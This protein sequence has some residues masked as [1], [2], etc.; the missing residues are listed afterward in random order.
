MPRISTKENRPTDHLTN[1]LT[2]S[3]ELGPSLQATSCVATQ[4][5]PNILWNPKVHYCVHKSPPL[6]PFL[7]QI[8]PV[9]TALSYISKININ[10]NLPP[11]SRS[12]YRSLSYWL[13]HQNPTCISLHVMHATCSTHLIFLDLIILIILGEEYKL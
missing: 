5:F 13:S 11:S 2:N 10:I 8:N 12:S 9:R 7:S 3:V 6:V 4:E 1:Q